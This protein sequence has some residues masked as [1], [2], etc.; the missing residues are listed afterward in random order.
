M[1]WQLSHGSLNP[2]YALADLRHDAQV[3]RPE[4]ASGHYEAPN[5]DG[6]W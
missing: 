4:I 3:V 2:E 1:A 5:A 6:G